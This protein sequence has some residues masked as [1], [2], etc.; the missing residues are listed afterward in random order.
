MESRVGG[1][2]GRGGGQCVERR[3]GGEHCRGG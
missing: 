3:V 1:E 2:Q